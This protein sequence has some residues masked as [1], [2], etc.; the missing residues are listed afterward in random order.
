MPDT[1]TKPA[2]VALGLRGWMGLTLLWIAL[3]A[4][5]AAQTAILSNFGWDVAWYRA[6]FGWAPWIVLAP[7]VWWLANRAP[8]ARHTWR[9]TLPVHAAVC[10]AISIGIELLSWVVPETHPGPEMPQWNGPPAMPTPGRAPGSP[11]LGA[12]PPPDGGFAP[13]PGAAPG[14]FPSSGTPEARPRGSGGVHARLSIPVYFLL[15]AA[16]HALAHHR[17]ALE[18]ERA[19]RDAEIGL[20]RARLHALQTQLQPHF[21]FNA[22]NAVAAHLHTRP[23]LA[24]QTLCALAD[25]MRGVLDVSDQPEI[26][27]RRELAFIDHYL[28]VQSIRFGERLVIEREIDQTALDCLVPPL[29]LQPLV[30]NAVVHG[31]EPRP[32]ICVLSLRIRRD[33]PAGTLRLRVVNPLPEASAA[34]RRPVGAMLDFPARVGLANTRAR[35]AAL[36]GA[37]H[38]F[39]FRRVE[40]G[41]AAEIELPARVHFSPA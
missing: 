30:E 28:A 33:A 24:D 38:R 32:G 39:E 7:P 22:L 3:A 29:L 10:I 31:I 41:V 2:T 16:A 25:L 34:G 17:R 27:L 19:A 35:L 36:H 1:T 8:I 6:F 37:K 14:A 5:S 26:P 9:R 12:P 15:V 21:F 13:P 4:L 40:A 11:P 20:T 18:R 23:D